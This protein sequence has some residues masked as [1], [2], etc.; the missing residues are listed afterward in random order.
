MCDSILRSSF[1]RAV[2]PA[3]LCKLSI[4]QKL[5]YQQS[6]AIGSLTLKSKALIVIFKAR[7]AG[8]F[9]LKDLIGFCV[10]IHKS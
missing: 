4:A 7:L 10:V 9:A 2:T 6:Q 5:T 8:C 1:D 3:L